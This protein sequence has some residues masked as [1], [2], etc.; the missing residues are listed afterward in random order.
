MM[1]VPA[2]G[3]GS[4]GPERALANSGVVPPANLPAAAGPAPPVAGDSVASLLGELSQADLTKLLEI[5]DAIPRPGDQAQVEEL[6]RAA[7]EAVAARNTGHALDLLRQLAALDPALADTL[8][9]VP[10]LASILPGLEQLLSQLTAAALLHAEG[11]LSE[12]SQKLETATLRETSAGEVRPEIFLLVATALIEAGGL[13]NY[14]RSAAVSDACAET[15]LGAPRVDP[16]RWAPAP[17]ADPAAVN[18]PES[19]WR[20]SW[21][22]PIAVWLAS[23]LAAVG[24]CWWLRDEYLPLVCGL[25]AGGL[26]ISMAVAAAVNRFR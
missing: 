7:T 2:A 5:V 10:A 15:H 24:L 18:R 26:L 13:A 11:K 21:R 25:W 16:S 22:L 17:G 1:E 19:R 23:G 8:V 20:A 9:S 3:M 14:V 12:A 4:P 6:L